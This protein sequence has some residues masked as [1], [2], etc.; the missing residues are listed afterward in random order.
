MRTALAIC[1]VSCLLVSELATGQA[2]QHALVIGANGGLGGYVL[3]LE[4]AEADAEAIGGALQ[5]TGYD[6]TVLTGVGASRSSVQRAFERSATAVARGET[7]LLVFLG[8]LVLSDQGA[9]YWL[10]QESS[11]LNLDQTALHLDVVASYLSNIEAG[12]KLVV[13][14][15]VLLGADSETFAF[16]AM[17]N[18]ALGASELDPNQRLATNGAALV[19]ANLATAELPGS[20]GPTSVFAEAVVGALT[21]DVAD[22]GP[23]DGTLQVSELYGLLFELLGDGIYLAVG[24]GADNDWGVAQLPSHKAP[25]VTALADGPH[26]PSFAPPL[27]EVVS[28]TIR[29]VAN[30]EGASFTVTGPET[31]RDR[32]ASWSRKEAPTGVYTITYD[33]MPGKSTPPSESKRL[34]PGDEIVFFGV[35]TPEATRGVIRAE[36]I[37]PSIERAKYHALLFAVQ[38]YQD[39]RITDLEHPIDDALRLQKVITEEYTF[40]AS[41]TELVINPTR[42]DIL[43]KLLKMRRLGK[44]DNLLIFFAGHG[45]KDDYADQGYWWPVDAQKD[46]RANWISN[47]DIR[48]H[49]RSIGARHTLLVS[50]ACFAGSVLIRGGDAA[51]ERAAGLIY[52]LLSR[53]AMTSGA[54]ETVPDKSAF[55]EYLV[56]RLRENRDAYLTAER[57]FDR[58]KTAVVN[59]GGT[60]PLH[61]AINSA[62]DEGGDFVFVR[63]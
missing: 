17:M 2:R 5:T 29:V 6:V 24:P 27:D 63:R 15:T 11:P 42:S 56:K 62:G 26:E 51:E 13:T 16:L 1:A 32:G 55:L 58:L 21:Q 4:Y 34:L 44:D 46:N 30:D 19:L 60:T 14:N 33:P 18:Q 39:S 37:E 45:Q 43:G 40:D 3:P 25:E 47:S 59:N 52:G 7:F 61:R 31:F 35:F 28:G 38:D 22:F 49:I 53:K 57:L 9:Y 12:Q 20:G 41:A 54:N 8:Q 48:D 23:T 50:D 36:D 10:L